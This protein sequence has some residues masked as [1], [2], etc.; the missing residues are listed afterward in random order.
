MHQA[1]LHL[2]FSLALLCY[3]S[4][5]QGGTEYSQ[6]PTNNNWYW[7]TVIWNMN[8]YMEDKLKKSITLSRRYMPSFPLCWGKYIHWWHYHRQLLKSPSCFM[9]WQRFILK[10]EII[11]NNNNDN[12]SSPNCLSTCRYR[13][14]LNQVTNYA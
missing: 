13:A 4:L 6:H 9:F 3:E 8:S 12:K 14:V 10:I 2:Y 11:S 5:Y 1:A 7:K